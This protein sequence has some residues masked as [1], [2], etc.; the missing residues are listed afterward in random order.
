MRQ[1]A[2]KVA[3]LTAGAV[4]MLAAQAHAAVVIQVG[5]GNGAAGTDVTVDVTVSTGTDMVA[6]TQNDITFP[7]G[8]RIAAN[9]DGTP[10]CTINPAISKPQSTF[11]F[12][13][14]GCSGTAC[15]G[16][17]SLVLSFAAPMAIPDGSRLYTCTFS[18]DATATGTLALACAMPGASNLTGGALTT[19]CTD[20]SI[21]VGGGG[22]PTPTP[23]TGAEAAAIIHVGSA[24][25]MIGD[26]VDVDVTLAVPL[27]GTMVAG[28]Q[29]DITFSGGIG[30]A[31]SIAA[32]TDGTPD[33]TVNPAIQKPQSTF[34]FLPAGC[35][36]EAC[37]GMRSLILSFAAPTAIPDGSRL[38]TC[39][40]T[41]NST[42]ANGQMYPLTCAMPG[43][44]NLTGG[45]LTASCTDG[46]ISVGPGGGTPTG[47]PTPTATTSGV[48]G[49]PTTTP[50]VGG[51]VV[52][53][54][55]RT[56]TGGIIPTVR[57]GTDDDGCAIG[58][59]VA[60]GSGWM[61]LLP[62]AMLIWLRRRSR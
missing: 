24:S 46:E 30:A 10:A 15:T 35:S 59:P 20:G 33:C 25:G 49:T 58:S 27:L 34:G 29:N 60:S 1:I 62:A 57:R 26:T 39:K 55:T 4:L 11:G 12:L 54:A 8:A 17:R 45:A 16:M 13:P 61:L 14:A 23:T 2:M 21:V 47:S 5:T 41:I 51:T 50:T 3:G 38:Y 48:I 32:K 9:T 19:T 31:I 56:R 18:V 7:T 44:S 52:A 6:G 28:T 43:A 40:V 42:A 53:T 36:G 22:G 37:T